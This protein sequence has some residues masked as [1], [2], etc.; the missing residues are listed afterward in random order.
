MKYLFKLYFDPDPADNNTGGPDLDSIVDKATEPP[1]DANVDKPAEKSEATPPAK[2]FAWGD[3]DRRK[4]R[5]EVNDDLELEMGYEQEDDKGNKAAVKAKIKEIKEAAKF[6]Y[7]NRGAIKLGLGLASQFKQS[8]EWAKAFDS[9]QQ[10]MW[11]GGKI[12]TEF[13]NK[14]LSFLEGKAEQIQDKIDDKTDDIAE[15]EKD[16]AELDAESPQAR[17]LKRNINALKTT[18]NQ[19]TQALS[20]NKELQGKIDGVQKFQTDFTDSQKKQKED[21]EEKQTVELFNKEFG[22]LTSAEKK[23]GYFIDDPEDKADFEEKVRRQVGDLALKGKITN[24]DQFVQ[25]IRECAKAAFEKYSQRNERIISTYLKK[26][27]PPVKQPETPQRQTITA[28]TA[29]DAI[30]ELIDGA[31]EEVFA[32]KG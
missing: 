8:P 14:Q 23:D 7:E 28:K 24:D 31:S 30:D 16:L 15:M 5:Q 25:S 22:S 13:I 20:A 10:K 9:L 27:Q 32:G 1:A 4:S 21:A 6:Y 29:T 17:I 2:K 26:K 18:K 11:E 3:E 19:L 12:N